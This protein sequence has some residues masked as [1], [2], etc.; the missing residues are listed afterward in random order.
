MMRKKVNVKGE[1]HTTILWNYS[2]NVWKKGREMV[3]RTV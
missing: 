3:E 1:S 2:R